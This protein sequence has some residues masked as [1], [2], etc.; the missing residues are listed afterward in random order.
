VALLAAD[1]GVAA[2]ARV[3]ELTQPSQAF[4]FENV[5]SEPVPSVLRGFSAPVKLEIDRSDEQLAFLA[6]ND[7]DAFN[8][9]DAS[10]RLASRVLLELASKLQ[11][12]AA[13]ELRLPDGFV[14]AFRTT[15]TATDLDNSLQAYSLS[16]PDF[17]TLSLE[18]S[19]V[20]PAALCGALKF[21][22]RGLAEA[23]RPELTAK[24]EA[25]VPPSGEEFNTAPATVGRRAL[26]NT[27]LG[28]LSKL[29]DDDAQA[30]CLE[31]FRGATCMTESVAA[32]NCLA[33]HPGAARDQALG[34]FYARAKANKE[35]LVINKWFAMQAGADSPDALAVVKAL[36]EHESF[37]FNNPNTVRSVVNTFAGANQQHFHAAD[38]SGY[39]FICEQTLK[40]DKL[41]PQVAARLAGSFGQWRR[42]EPARGELMRQALE[43]IKSTDG[44]S[45][46]TFEIASKSLA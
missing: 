40:L 31:Q 17:N 38:G 30:L 13:A 19:P 37:E 11:A 32:V 2:A 9:W 21:A 22:R 12:D 6:A 45:K 39:D 29:G 3:L 46:D 5:A 41:N 42:Y 25:L 43:R 35:T 33:S 1:G 20:D 26:R 23:L 14:A 44:V 28:Y 4:V 18:M 10:Q 15:L 36:M 8:K 16:L 24:Y 34:E 27:C 7:D